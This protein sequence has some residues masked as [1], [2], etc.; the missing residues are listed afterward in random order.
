MHLR[1]SRLS[2]LVLIGVTIVCALAVGYGIAT[3]TGGSDRRPTD[4]V[5]V[6]STVTA[7]TETEIST[8]SPETTPTEPIVETPETTPTEEPT[9]TPRASAAA[10]AFIDEN[11]DAPSSAFPPREEATWSATY[12]EGR[13]QLQL[14]GQR[15]IGLAGE[16]PAPNYRLMVDVAVQQGGAGIVFLS[17]VPNTSYRFLLSSDGA[18]SIERQD[19][20]NVTKVVDWTVSSALSPV[21]GTTQQIRVERRADEITFFVNGRKLTSFAVPSTTAVNSYGFVVTSRTGQGLALFDNLRAE[22]LEASP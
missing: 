2:Q 14:N 13:Y 11:F 15:N 20:T 3:V 16:L 9:A 7:E 19:D 17:D 10:Q 6:P 18:Y 4:I 22:R 8:P 12:I 1:G 21:P 5:F